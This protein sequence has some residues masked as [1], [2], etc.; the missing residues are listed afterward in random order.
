MNFSEKI[1]GDAVLVS[2]AGRID[3]SNADAFKDALAASL[4]KAKKALILDLSGVDY[5]SSAG[6]RSLMIVFKAGKTEGKA[7]GIAALQ[8]L[9]MEIFTI[10][11]FNLVFPLF[12]TVQLAVEK[13]APGSNA[14]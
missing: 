11:R 14:S 3:L 7:F 10:S 1:L 2:A 12:D 8:P 13:L 4:A 6:L 9:L 5:I